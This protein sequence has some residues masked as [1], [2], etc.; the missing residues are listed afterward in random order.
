MLNL[1]I[2]TL[3]IV[4][5]AL[6]FLTNAIVEI[7]KMVFGAKGTMVLN[8]IALV[9]AIVLAVVTYLTYAA[10]T[11]TPIVWY[12]FVGAI[13]LGFIVALISMLGWDKV[14]KMWQESQ[15]KGE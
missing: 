9:T 8:K 1:N 11:S 3:F 15:K 14:L 7:A 2:A 10:Y 5:G 12:Y 13:I 6:V 4:M